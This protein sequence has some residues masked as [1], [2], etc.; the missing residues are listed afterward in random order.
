MGRTAVKDN[1]P[2]M[3]FVISKRRWLTGVLALFAVSLMLHGQATA[4]SPSARPV[5]V[6]E[7]T[8]GAVHRGRLLRLAEDGAIELAGGGSVVLPGPEV[9][10]LRRER[11]PLPPRPLGS[12]I[13]FLNG[14]RLAGDA[15][16]LKGE[17]LV[18]RP[19]VAPIRELT[20]PL[21]LLSGLWRSAPEGEEDTDHFF[22]SWWRQRRRHDTLLLRNS[23]TVE[24]YVAALGDRKEGGKFLRLQADKKTVDVDL[25][26]VSALGLAAETDH[27]PR[28]RVCRGHLILADGSRL[29]YAALRAENDSFTGI[30]LFGAEM[31]LPLADVIAVYPVQSAVTPLS[32]LQPADYRYTPYF[33][34]GT[35]PFNRDA[36]AAGNDLLLG[37]STYDRGI[38]M[39]SQSRLTYRLDGGY[40]SFTALVGMDDHTGQ[41]GSARVSILVDDK[42]TALE[43]EPELTAANGPRR[44]RLNVSGAHRL[45]LVVDYGRRGNVQGHVDWADPLLIK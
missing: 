22:R 13:L 34:E 30:T 8:T 12:Q 39:R 11:V 16:E 35:L 42:P 43:G 28:G 44:V 37:G 40:R 23:D 24:G 10:S 2:M 15:V 45:T 7:T 33:G 1:E 19:A 14:D 21:A 4:S 26:Q 9:I 41:K 5:F 20:V 36:S 32:D 38:G 6:I 27:P 3:H 29:G 18:F 17:R 31:R 25:A